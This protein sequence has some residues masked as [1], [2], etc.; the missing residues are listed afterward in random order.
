M[1][2]QMNVSPTPA[3]AHIITRIMGCIDDL[4]TFEFSQNST[5]GIPRPAVW[6]RWKEQGIWMLGFIAAGAEGQH[7]GMPAPLLK[8]YNSLSLLA[9]CEF[10]EDEP[11]ADYYIPTYHEMQPP[12][13]GALDAYKIIPDT[14][15]RWTIE[16]TP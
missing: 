7:C 2:N 5:L 13:R 8:C 14:I 16:E 6:L 4:S 3:Q 1:D 11:D 12:K 10:E 15:I 9:G